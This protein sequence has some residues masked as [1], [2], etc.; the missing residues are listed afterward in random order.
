MDD[1]GGSLATLLDLNS[2]VDHNLSSTSCTFT[3]DAKQQ[4][5]LLNIL[6]FPDPR[7]PMP[8]NL[9]KMLTHG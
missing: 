9:S 2:Y 1:S 7:L 4:M 6:E 5:A 8:P 3:T